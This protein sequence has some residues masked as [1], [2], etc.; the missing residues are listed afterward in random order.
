M[1]VVIRKGNVEDDFGVGEHLGG[2]ARD[3]CVWLRQVPAVETLLRSQDEHWS[4]QIVEVAP[5]QGDA[6]ATFEAAGVW[7]EGSD[8]RLVVVDGEGGPAAGD[9]ELPNV[10]VRIWPLVNDSDNRLADDV[11]RGHRASQFARREVDGCLRKSLNVEGNVGTEGPI[12]HLLVVVDVAERA[13]ELSARRWL[14]AR[15]PDSGAAKQGKSDATVLLQAEARFW[16]QVRRDSERGVLEAPVAVREDEQVLLDWVQQRGTFSEEPA[17]RGK[18]NPIQE[19]SRNVPDP[20]ILPKTEGLRYLAQV[21]DQCCVFVRDA[22]VMSGVVVV[23]GVVVGSCVVTQKSDVGKNSVE[24]VIW[25]VQGSRLIIVRRSRLPE[26]QHL[27]REATGELWI[28]RYGDLSDVGVVEERDRA[29]ELRVLQREDLNS[30]VVEE[31]CREEATPRV[32]VARPAT[33]EVDHDEVGQPI[34]LVRH[35]ALEL[36]EAENE[37]AH[38]G[39]AEDRRREPAGESRVHRD[40][41]LHVLPDAGRELSAQPVVELDVHLAKLAQV[42]PVVRKWLAKVVAADVEE[43]QVRQRRAHAS[44]NRVEGIAVDVE[45]DERRAVAQ[46]FGEVPVEAILI[47]EERVEVGAVLESA[48]NLTVQIVARELEQ[49]E[50]VRQDRRRDRAADGAEAEVELVQRGFS[51]LL[52]NVDSRIQRDLPLEV[53]SPEQDVPEVREVREELVVRRQ[54]SRQVV[55]AEVEFVKVPFAA[56]SDAVQLANDPRVE[57][58]GPASVVRPVRSSRD[59]EEVVEGFLRIVGDR[60]REGAWRS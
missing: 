50:L 26:L 11:E 42:A 21:V 59:V 24:L 8:R 57:A 27:R 1:V 35:L 52:E 46:S 12:V 6:S 51:F 30:G 25:N 54:G 40:N 34:E 20:V 9:I 45:S 7:N 23:S 17:T 44:R 38:L 4:R 58:F 41:Y 60:G 56:A 55:P 29:A 18:G 28:S 36:A 53:V 32:A 33:F 15:R 47:Q 37:R 13:K 3:D 5:D 16:D 22:V 10:A 48:R 2:L 39:H 19:R 43:F 31:R 49:V 14:D